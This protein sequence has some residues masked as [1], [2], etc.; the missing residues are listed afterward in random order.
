MLKIWIENK[1]GTIW[2]V[3]ELISSV[4]WKTGRNGKV[5]SLD[6]TLI[7]G[8]LYEFDDF[9][10][11]PGDIIHVTKDST[12][13]FY[14]YIFTIDSG[15]DEEVKLTA[16][17]QTR[18]LL[19]NHTYVLSNVTATQIIERIAK[20]YQMKVGSLADTGYTIPTVIEDG[21]KL[22]DIICKALDNTLMAT[23]KLYHLYDD[24]GKLT[25]RN[26]EDMIIEPILGDESLVYDYKQKR[27]ID[28]D[29]YNRIK[30]VK[31]NKDS[32]EREAYIFQDSNNIAK[33]GLLQFYQKV[34]SGMNEAKIKTM[35]N[36][37]LQ[38]KN[39]EQRSFSIDAIG[40]IQFRAGSYVWIRMQ[41]P[42]VDQRFLIEECTHKF[43]GVDHTMSLELRVYG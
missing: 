28:N 6:V 41:E 1:G 32:G 4:T 23:G 43:D 33:W 18:Y 14:G 10:I 9:Q 15:R 19:T 37:T 29:V 11:N 42:K 21:S 38:L 34:D 40:D 31:D 17:D 24:F 16:F 35:L 7:S 22:M 26:T 5:S 39:R 27:S 13:V 25:L 8:G 30:L 36:N 3:A 2:D 20:D 12:P